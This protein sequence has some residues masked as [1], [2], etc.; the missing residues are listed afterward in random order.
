VADLI[1]RLLERAHLREFAIC[2]EAAAALAAAERE[3]DEAVRRYNDLLRTAKPE[4]EAED[5]S[6][7]AAS[8]LRPWAGLA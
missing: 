1:T 3:R 4:S 6:T 8:V 5:T 2:Q 7:G